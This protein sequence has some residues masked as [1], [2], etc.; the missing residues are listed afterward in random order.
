MI[1][2]CSLEQNREYKT[3]ETLEQRIIRPRTQLLTLL[4]EVIEFE[5]KLLIMKTYAFMIDVNNFFE[6][7]NASSE[8]FIF[9]QLEFIVKLTQRNITN[10]IRNPSLRILYETNIDVARKP[11]ILFVLFPFDKR[12]SQV[13]RQGLTRF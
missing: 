6:L 9:T 11:I 3:S 8:N 4:H 2:K 5:R 1:D 12:S 10:A 7:F 13:I